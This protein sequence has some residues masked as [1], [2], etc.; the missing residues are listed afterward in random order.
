MEWETPREEYSFNVFIYNAVTRKYF[1]EPQKFVEGHVYIE[2][3]WP[4]QPGWLA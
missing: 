3:G 2:V 4:D 1:K